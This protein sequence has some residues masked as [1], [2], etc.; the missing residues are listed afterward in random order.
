MTDEM[1]AM[2][3]TNHTVADQTFVPS[4]QYIYGTSVP[5]LMLATELI[6]ADPVNAFDI[7]ELEVHFIMDFQPLSGA[8]SPL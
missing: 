6:H 4:K 8:S 2:N 7:A 3:R 5:H 1:I